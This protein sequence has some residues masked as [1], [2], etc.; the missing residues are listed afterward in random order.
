MVNPKGTLYMTAN[1]ASGSKFYEL[2]PTQQDYIAERSQN[3][4]PSYSVIDMD[5][6]SFSIT[7][8]QITAEGKVEAIDDT[9]TIEKTAA[10]SSINTLEAGGVTYYRLRD[11]AAAVSGQDNQFNVS[12]DNGVVITTGAAYA[13]AVPAGAPASGSAVTLTLTVDGKSVTTPA[14]LANGNYYLPASFYGTL[15]VTPAA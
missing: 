10:P 3:W 14:V 8:Y 7:T 12:W 6:D 9:F 15:G 1:S 4:L 13:D 2:I 5:S 11:V